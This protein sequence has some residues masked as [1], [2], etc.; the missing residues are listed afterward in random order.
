MQKFAD[1]PFPLLEKFD[2]ALFFADVS[3]F[4]AILE[5]LS[6]TKD[7]T[8]GSEVLSCILLICSLPLPLF[9]GHLWFL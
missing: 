5:K 4:S 1:T 9:T 6:Q 2:G 7:L 8:G 3:S